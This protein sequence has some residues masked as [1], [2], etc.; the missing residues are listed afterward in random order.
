MKVHPMPR[1]RNITI[2]YEMNARN[3]FAEAQALLGLSSKKLRRLPH[4]FSRVLELPFRSDAD[5]SIEEKPDCF[6]FIAETNN[7]ISDVRAHTVE[8]YPGVTKIVVRESGSL[9]LSL[10]ELELDMW[11]FRLP[12]STR[13]DLASAVF[14]DGE[15]IVTVPKGDVGVE[16]A[17]EKGVGGGGGGDEEF[18]RDGNGGGFRGGIGGRLVLVQ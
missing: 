14:V 17:G 4:I 11:R 8:I 2:Q 9:E 5:V 7:D 6:R 12:E 16:S 18:W 13:P 3:T 15:L 10:D 1:K